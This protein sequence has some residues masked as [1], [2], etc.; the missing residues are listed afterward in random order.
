MSTA[1]QTGRLD[2]DFVQHFS[3]KEQVAVTFWRPQTEG[4]DVT[5]LDDACPISYVKSAIVADEEILEIN[6]S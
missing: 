2:S 5:A 4:G 6:I 3:E 1:I